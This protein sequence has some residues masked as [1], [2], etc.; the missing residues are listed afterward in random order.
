MKVNFSWV[1]FWIGMV[2]LFIEKN[3]DLAQVGH[4]TLW[5]FG[6][7]GIVA[8]LLDLDTLLRAATCRSKIG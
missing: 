8:V 6:L 5:Q 4:A 2:I 3:S 7:S 1:V